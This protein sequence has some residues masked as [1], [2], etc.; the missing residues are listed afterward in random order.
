MET[1]NAVQLAK[2]SVM[3]NGRVGSH[4]LDIEGLMQGLHLVA[5]VELR[6][7]GRGGANIQH[8][9]TGWARHHHEGEY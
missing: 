7:W 5:M 1:L 3:V 6:G 4:R 9:G 8:E 2:S